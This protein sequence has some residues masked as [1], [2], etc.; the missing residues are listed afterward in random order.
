MPLGPRINDAILGLVA[1]E[2]R[3]DPFFRDAFNAVFQRSLVNITQSFLRLTHTNP[4]TQLRQEIPSAGEADLAAARAERDGLA[5]KLDLLST[6][7]DELLRRTSP[8]PNA[9]LRDLEAFDR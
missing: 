4:E 9:G 2:H 3:V 1:L 7:M 8:A 5:A 6:Q